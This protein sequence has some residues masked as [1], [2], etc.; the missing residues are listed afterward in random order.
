MYVIL[1]VCIKAGTTSVI[2]KHNIHVRVNE[3]IVQIIV[4]TNL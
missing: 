1:L 2:V 3:N 4:Y